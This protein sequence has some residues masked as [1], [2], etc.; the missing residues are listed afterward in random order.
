L[1][2]K[3]GPDG[4]KVSDLVEAAKSLGFEKTSRER[5]TLGE[6]RDAIREELF[7]IVYVATPTV[8]SV[9]VVAIEDFVEVLDPARPSAEYKITLET[10]LEQWGAERGLAVILRR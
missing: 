9:V 8:H 4:T 6:L 1:R 7:P 3:A 10:F 2:V 5:L